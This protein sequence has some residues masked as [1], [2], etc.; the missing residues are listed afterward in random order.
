[1]KLWPGRQLFHP[2][3]VL[4]VF[5]SQ[6]VLLAGSANL[7]SRA[8][9]DQIEAIGRQSWQR[10]GLP[11]A[12]RPLL[13]TIG[14]KMAEQMLTLPSLHS[15]SFHTSLSKPFSALLPSRS[16]DEI[17]IV[18][19]F[20]DRVEGADPDDFGF[21]AELASHSPECNLAIILPTEKE[22][23]VTSLR[24]HRKLA[25][26]WGDRAK[27]YGIDPR[28]YGG[29]MLHAKLLALRYGDSVNVLFGSANATRAG[30][31]G[32]NVE[33]DWFVRLSR[34]E[35]RKWLNQQSLLSHPLN[36][37]KCQF[38]SPPTRPEHHA[39]PLLAAT[40]L[41][42]D[43]AMQLAWRNG[44][45]KTGVRIEY[46]GR[47]LS[48]KNNSIRPFRIGLDWYLTVHEGHRRWSVPIE[49]LGEVAGVRSDQLYAEDPAQLLASITSL[50][51]ADDDE[52]EDGKFKEKNSRA[53]SSLPLVSS[54]FDRVRQLTESLAGARHWL[55][56][57]G[58][59]PHLATLALLL[60]I[61]NAHDP[62]ASGIDE[63]EAVWRY[64]VRAEIAREVRHSRGGRERARASRRLSTLLRVSWRQPRLA[65][66]YRAI[67]KEISS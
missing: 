37:N 19:P 17:T 20:Y 33:A 49:V 3:L 41:S 48:F 18:S 60:R 51:L 11:T 27:F 10:Q 42:E 12:L 6:T 5:R 26:Q 4:L 67:R 55:Q 50:P 32:A 63:T 65:N 1:M 29:R 9:V 14:G 64:W 36:I 45:P 2:K 52:N 43:L 44:F 40:F 21:V 54:M 62:W 31:S 53:G 47:S 24:F 34:A 28:D 16:P 25:R 38:L 66:A 61:A 59:G 7:T 35:F 56:T 46:G 15:R 8:H 58:S 39:C 57:P 13:K 30:M 23:G 22:D